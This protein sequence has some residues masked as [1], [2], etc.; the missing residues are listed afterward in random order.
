M[1]VAMF[2]HMFPHFWVTLVKLNIWFRPAALES[3]TIVDYTGKMNG[4]I[5]S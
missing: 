5:N 4:I 3:Q 1:Q 2:I